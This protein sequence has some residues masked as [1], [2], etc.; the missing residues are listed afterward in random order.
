MV[1]AMVAA[2]PAIADVNPADYPEIELGK[3]YPM[4]QY[5][6]FRGRYTATEKGQIVEYAHVP[7]FLLQSGQ[8]ELMTEET[9]YKYAGFI[10]GKQAY[11]FPVTPGV[12]Y[13]FEDSFVMDDGV[14][15]IELNPELSLIKCEPAIG[16]VYHPA[17]SSYIGFVFNQNLNIG[18]VTLTIGQLMAEVE[19]H[20]TVSNTSVMIND[21]LRQWYNEGKIKGGEELTITLMDIT[22]GAGNKVDNLEY[23]FEVAAKP[24]EMSSAE[25]PAEILSWYGAD[26]SAKAVFTFT[27]AMAADPNIELCYAPVELGYEYTEKLA[28]KVDGNVITV[29]F[30]GVRRTSEEM[31]TTGRTDAQIYLLL[32][33]LK[34]AEGNT[35]WSVNQGTIGSFMYEIPFA[36]I[37]R[38]DITSEFTPSLGSSLENAKDVKIYFTCA[39]HLAYEGV[40]FTS[41]T[42]RVMVTE[43]IT[44]DRISDSEV[45]LTVPIPAGWNT[46]ENVYVSLYGL[47][48]DDGF[49]HTSD[50]SAK[51]NGFTLIYCSLKNGSRI[52]S[53]AKGAIVKVETNLGANDKL[54]FEIV[55]KFGPVEMTPSGDGIF[56]FTMPEAIVFEKGEI[57]TV[58][59]IATPGG[60][61]SLTLYGDST[62]Y[63][64]SDLELTEITPADGSDIS[65][66]TEIKLTF[67]GLVSIQPVE[68]SVEFTSVANNA[69]EPGY[70][71]EWTL[72]LT[73]VKEGTVTLAFSAMDMDYNVVKGNAGVDAD[74]HFVY[75]FNV[76]SA[77]IIEISTGE[78]NII[79][80]LQGRQVINP[81]NGIFICN[82]KKVKL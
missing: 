62:P 19:F 10:N 52:K 60:V 59:F 53:L 44:V 2:F 51:F 63:E 50:I 22:D 13:Y 14:F 49:D 16:S 29:D 37:P 70:D 48:A 11:Q 72:T 39:D 71:F 31:S 9:G 82:G 15:S 32:K 69:E 57:F 25:L 68:G 8:L 17:V 34:D 12:T 47:V 23:K 3:E 77:G 33:N 43:G 35:V 75:T 41:G 54:S 74:S 1:M 20:T 40:A 26:E 45:E 61:E 18:K 65:A 80:D 55:N 7:V 38:L 76:T 73:N 79:Y 67:T 24:V 36:E 42:E 27:G 21:P 64:F 4:V 5:K 56:M 46:K 66:D 28:A 81:S 58:N 30:G 78:R 6:S